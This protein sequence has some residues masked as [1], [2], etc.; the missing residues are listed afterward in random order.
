MAVA[1]S[2]VAPILALFL[3]FA[4]SPLFGSSL[5]LLWPTPNPAFQLGQ[6]LEDYV[7]PTSSGR[8][9]SG[10]FGCVRNGGAKFHEGLDLFPV[11]RSRRGE[12]LDPIYSI[13]PGRVVHISRRSGYSS[14]GRY[15]VVKHEDEVLPFHSLYAHMASISSDL[16]VGGRVD[17]GT[18]L[19]IM[20]RSASGYTIPR[21]RSHLHLELGFR[22]TGDFQAWFDRQK[23]GSENRHG[24]WNGMNLVSVDPL[25]FYE[26][27]RSGE[28]VDMMQF[29]KRLPVAA[30]IR[31]HSARVPSFVQTYPAL[32]S[33]DYADRT[34]VAWDIAFSKFGVPKEW[35]PR[36]A[37]ENLSGRPGDVR[38]LTYNP[39]LLESQ[40]C[41]RLL[42][43]SGRVPTIAPSTVVLIQKLF[44]FQ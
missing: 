8:V 16:S 42:T 3:P 40:A 13:L 41:R 19:G 2:K 17:A 21:S 18:V 15:I 32:L 30:R 14:Y 4:V 6:A 37:S 5:G 35:T 11:E 7:Q 28:V 24:E 29:L 1:I 39:N 43:M 44:G 12:A 20:G 26:A 22:L 23:F 27:M 38:V 33:R 9:E 36:F 31:V 25:A 34:V 10:L